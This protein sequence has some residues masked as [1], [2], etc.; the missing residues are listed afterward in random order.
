MIK[1]KNLGRKEFI[2]GSLILII[3]MNIANF[4]HYLFQFFTAR[5]LI[6]ADYGILAVL[7]AIVYIL[8]IPTEGIQNIV[9]KYTSKFNIKREYG[10]MKYFLIKSLKKAFLISFVL[11]LIYIPISFLI[12]YFVNIDV[13]LIIFTGF[14]I[15]GVFLTAIVRGIIQGRKKFKLLGASLIIEAGLKFL[16]ALILV[17][18][19]LK[20]YGAMTAVIFSVFFSL[21][22]S[23]FFIKEVNSSKEEKTPVKNIYCNSFPILIT[24]LTVTLMASLD[25]IFAKGFFSPDMAG[26][27]AVAS[28]LGKMI[29]F[30]TLGISKAMFPLTSENFEM[31]N[32]T[33]KLFKDAFFIVLG[34]CILGLL[35]F[36][37]FPKLII[38]IFFGSKYLEI[39][40][41]LFFIGIALSLLSLSN[42][43]LIYA[44]SIN[45]KGISYFFFFVLLEVVI[46][47]L[48][49]KNL[50]E[51]SIGFVIANF[52]MFVFSLIF[53]IR[54]L[55]K[56]ESFNNNSSS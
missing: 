5:I 4:I 46:F 51:F 45:K 52:I 24:A 10:K 32:K 41:I 14:L 20:V 48:F 56:N 15:L 28:M 1:I 34:I 39:S 42:V 6:P 55:R 11:F 18:L 12:S 25:I 44:I 50:I 36:L 23:L 2:K 9:S 53:I 31:R 37:F 38:L 43:C 16:I 8:A 35:V 27:Y 29:F 21:L 17:I 22:I 26:K 49:H 47:S 33:E 19:G 54:G 3:L 13:K 40:G 30:G 7:M